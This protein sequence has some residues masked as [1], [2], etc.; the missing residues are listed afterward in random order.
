MLKSQK[1][2]KK[3]YT[4]RKEERIREREPNRANLKTQKYFRIKYKG[5]GGEQNPKKMT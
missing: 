2:R 4:I 1:P 3:I 5:E